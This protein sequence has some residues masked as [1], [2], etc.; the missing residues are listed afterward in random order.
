MEELIE[1]ICDYV[2]KPYIDYAIMLNGEWGSGKT[3]FWNNKLRS[4]LESITVNGKNYKTIYMSLYGINSL[5]EISKKIFIETNPMI[6]KTLKKF[7]DT[8]EGNLI[9]EY[10]KTGL[11]MANM[12]GTMSFNSEKVDFSKLFA[13]DNKILCFDDLERANVDVIDILGYINNFVEHDGIKT[14]VICNEKELATKFKNTN[15]EFK[16]LIAAYILDKENKL[17]VTVKSKFKIGDKEESPVPIGNLI[18]EKIAEIFDKANAYER[19]KEKL[20][21]ETFEYIPEYSYI[22]SGMIMKYSY[23]EK[24]SDFFKRNTSLI[25]AAFNKSETRN[26][27]ILKH[28]LT[29][30]EKIFDNII[31]DFPDTPINVLRN[32]ITFTIAVSFEIKAGNISKEKLK[33]IDNNSEYNSVVFTS[34]ILN[35]KSQFYLR[36]FDNKYFLNNTSNFK[37]F[38]FVEVYIRTRFFDEKLYKDNMKEATD[39]ID[40]AKIHNNKKYYTILNGEYLKISDY[41]FNMLV[42]QVLDEIKLGQVEFKE[43]M[44]L[45]SIYKYF[46]TSGLLDMSIT[47]LKQSFILGMQVSASKFTDINENDSENLHIEIEDKDLAEIKNQY[48][49]IK[50]QVI[51]DMSLKKALELFKNLP[52]NIQQFYKDII[53]DYQNLPVFSKYDM[54]DLY[55]KLEVTSNYDLYNLV[56]MFSVRY[57][58]K[59]ELFR[60]DSKN[61]K[62]L[63]EIIRKNKHVKEKTIKVVLLDNIA[64]V[65]EKL[66]ENVNYI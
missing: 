61:L 3:Y 36:E 48:M 39:F 59:A 14:I 62:K 45:F 35:D 46:V 9:P 1:C 21:G 32:L 42:R 27:R 10:V 19:I 8:R 54:E 24:L 41:E 2:R 17:K 56:N 11:D 29:D 44:Q 31:R 64:D 22:L 53:G 57:K 37:F 15:V 52:S 65:I 58:D 28:S 51:E 38:K 25:I 66:D 33:E 50:G 7:V 63:C 47:D 6:S 5:E 49:K 30:F 43:H 20:I 16:T 40:T 60:Q 26:L 12:F 13:I 34:K 23:N 18:E 55:T 4:R